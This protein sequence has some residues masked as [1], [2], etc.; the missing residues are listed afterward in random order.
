MTHGG[1]DDDERRYFRT[2]DGRL[3]DVTRQARPPRQVDWRRVAAL[4]L[5]VVL[6]ALIAW[7]LIVLAILTLS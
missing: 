7:G 2:T 6:G 1:G 3:I 5:A 4:V